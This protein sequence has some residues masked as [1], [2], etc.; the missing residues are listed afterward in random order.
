MKSNTKRI[1]R[2][3]KNRFE[4]DFHEPTGHHESWEDNQQNQTQKG[5][6]KDKTPIQTGGQPMKTQTRGPKTLFDNQRDV[7]N[8]GKTTHETKYE[9]LASWDLVTWKNQGRTNRS[10]SR[11]QETRRG[12]M[13]DHQ[14]LG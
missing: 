2:D 10:D 13:G 11:T 12:T 4:D 9:C 8:H 1:L 14:H 3:T 7:K 6:L 5:I